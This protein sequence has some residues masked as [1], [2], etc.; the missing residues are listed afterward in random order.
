MAAV[1]FFKLSSVDDLDVCPHTVVTDAAILVTRHQMISRV[2]EPGS[3]FCDEARHHHAV[4]ICIRD[5]KSVDDVG[6][7]YTKDDWSL[8]RND[9]TGGHKRV[10]LRNDAYNH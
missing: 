3:H 4:H 8:R 6:A 2:I 9:H 1:G 7:S 10:L 5:Q